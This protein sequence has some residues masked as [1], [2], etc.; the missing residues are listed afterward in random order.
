MQSIV[1][2][3]ESTMPGIESLRKDFLSENWPVRMSAFA[4]KGLRIEISI[5]M[6]P[7]KGQQIHCF[8]LSQTHCFDFECAEVVTN[9]LEKCTYV[10]ANVVTIKVATNQNPHERWSEFR[11]QDIKFFQ[12][13]EWSFYDPEEED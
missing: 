5:P 10:Y 9:V 12:E 6:L 4:T 8:P 2:I 13:A 3:I 1:F 7:T 11:P